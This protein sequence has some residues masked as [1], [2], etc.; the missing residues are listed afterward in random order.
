MLSDCSYR[1]GAK[2]SHL[3]SLFALL[4]IVLVAGCSTPLFKP[5]IAL[6]ELAFE[7]VA[8]AN[9]N[10]PFAIE[11]VSTSDDDLLKKL[12]ALSAAQWFD[13]QAN[14]KRDFPTL[15][16]D[17]YELTPGQDMTL[18]PTKFTNKPGKGLLLFANYKTPGQHRLRLET[19]HK[20]KII[21]AADAIRVDALP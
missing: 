2:E 5:K 11:L 6:R 7:V 21:F 9:D 4:C 20:A 18:R 3:K 19:L 13:G 1:C 10:S 14:I 17:Y 12:Q 15:T 16:F 8:G